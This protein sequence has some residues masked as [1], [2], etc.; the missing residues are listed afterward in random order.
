MVS[1]AVEQAALAT[2]TSFAETVG[3]QRI[4]AVT[5]QLVKLLLKQVELF[6][7]DTNALNWHL[8]VSGYDKIDKLFLL[9]SYE[10]DVVLENAASN[11]LG[12]VYR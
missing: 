9:P 2:F 3:E 1:A 12:K 8:Q 11:V 7:K 10:D 5:M 4:G 6:S